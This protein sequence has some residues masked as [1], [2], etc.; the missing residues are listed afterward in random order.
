MI[1]QLAVAIG[2]FLT[3]HASH[4]ASI[5]VVET[6]AESPAYA[7][8]SRLAIQQ[9]IENYP[10]ASIIDYL[11]MGSV[12]KKELTEA[13]FRL[14]LREGSR[15]YGIVVR[16]RYNTQTEQLESIQFQEITPPKVKET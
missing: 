10:N 11:Y 2:L 14:W 4:Q 5:E 8:W 12:P 1:I 15:E 9:T 16:V 6:A 3:S 13:S 7:K